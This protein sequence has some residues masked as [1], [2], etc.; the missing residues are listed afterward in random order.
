MRISLIGPKWN[1]MINSYPPLGLGYLAAIAEQDGHE[2]RIHDFGLYPSTTVDQDAQE[3]I[4]FKPHLIGF[5][6]MTTSYHYVEQLVARLKDALGVPVIIGG[7]HATTLPDGTLANPHIDYLIYGE[8]EYIW[9]D[10]LRAF[11]SGDTRWGSIP[12]LWYKEDGRIVPGGSRK[13][14][15]DL[16]ALPFP[17]RHLYEL[18]KY[19]LYA[20]NGEPMLTVLSSR[21]CPY[22]CSFCFKGIVGRSYHQR[23]PENIV[24]EL[25]LVNRTYGVRNFYFIDDLFTIDVRRLERILDYFIEQKLDFRWRCLARVDRVTPPLL[26]K[27]YQAGCRQIHFGIESGNEEVLR[28]TAKHINLQQVR[29]AV[30][31]TE[32][33]GIRSKGYFILGLPGDTEE[34]MQE[35]IEFAASL[36][37]TE[38][39]FSIATPFPGT[40]LWDELV[41]KNPGLVYNADFT[42]SYYYN[43]YTA[44]IA[45]FMNV[46]EV[47]DEQLS[48]MALKARQRFQEAKEQRKFV[49]YFG[50]VWGKRVYRLSKVKP[51]HAAA[52]LVLDAGL[53]PRFRQLQPREGA[54]SWA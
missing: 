31:W 18:K 1:E 24:E 53:F 40:K 47:G 52:K 43:N 20:P 32:E 45:P 35:T 17:A 26:K 7:P 49:K 48:G 44:E 9:R 50:P 30:R 34:T 36:D 37:L 12:G 6:S 41:M 11:T 54:S 39:M 21:G 33:A 13:P 22:A 16:D 51:V 14:I 4:D 3:V 5:T 23:S 19:P 29:D 15:E 42:K 28:R 25:K 8:G 38:A 2:V 27:M 46:S 10:F